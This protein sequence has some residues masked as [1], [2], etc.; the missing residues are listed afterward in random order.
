M[1]MGGGGVKVDTWCHGF[2]QLG[3]TTFLRGSP[4]ATVA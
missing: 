4:A 2:R 1:E 3:G